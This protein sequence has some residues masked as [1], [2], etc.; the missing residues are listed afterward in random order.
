MRQTL[1]TSAEDMEERKERERERGGKKEEKEILLYTLPARAA[2][3]AF[4]VHA[5]PEQHNKIHQSTGGA[6]FKC[7]QLHDSRRRKRQ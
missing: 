3:A 6:A 4:D 5:R 2:G 1:Q 7:I